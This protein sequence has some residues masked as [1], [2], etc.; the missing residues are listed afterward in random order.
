MA[1][2]AKDRS[3]SLIHLPTQTPPHLLLLLPPLDLLADPLIK[4]IRH[5]RKRERGIIVQ[6]GQC[7]DQLMAA[8]RLAARN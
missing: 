1:E 5:A 7:S 8:A 3:S 6:G 2:V 4:P